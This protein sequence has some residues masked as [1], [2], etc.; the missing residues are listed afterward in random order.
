MGETQSSKVERSWRPAL[1]AR[2]HGGNGAASVG[3]PENLVQ[4]TLLCTGW[5]LDSCHSRCSPLPSTWGGLFC[6]LLHVLCFLLRGVLS[7]PCL[8]TVKICTD[9]SRKPLNLKSSVP[10]S[11]E[12][13]SCMRM[14]A[15]E[16]VKNALW[17]VTAASQKCVSNTFLLSCSQACL[18][19][20]IISLRFPGLMESFCGET[21]DSSD[22][23][24]GERT[25][26][27]MLISLF[28]KVT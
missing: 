5:E 14:P 26:R 12:R 23:A 7:K 2:M 13:V 20:I 8:A 17:H 16:P 11:R 21:E 22:D 1:H 18:I 28:Q 6:F 10:S 15:R 19:L 25:C 27:F 3:S 9:N 24:S 4:V